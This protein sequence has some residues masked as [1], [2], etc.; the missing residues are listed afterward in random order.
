[1]EFSIPLVSSLTEIEA[2]ERSGVAVQAW[3]AAI[4]G[5][6]Y[7]AIRASAQRHGDAP[8][9]TY[10]DAADGPAR[11]VSYRE[12]LDNITA[13][14]RFFSELA[15]PGCG[16][17]YILPSFVETHYVLWG[18]E[19]CGFAVPLNPFLQ[20]DEI[21]NLVR[22]SAADVLVFPKGE[23]PGIAERVAAIR[24]NL[25]DVRL[26]AVGPGSAADFAI[27]FNAVLA[28]ST[29]HGCATWEPS[30]D[31]DA[32]VAYFHTGGTTGLPKLVAHSSRNQLAAALGAASLL[33]MRKDDRVTNGMPLFHVGGTIVSTLSVLLS[34]GHIIMLSAQ[35]LRNPAMVTGIWK[36]VER[37]GITI[38]GAVPTALGA[39]LNVPVD[40]DISSIRYGLTGA[41]PCPFSV[42]KRFA[43]VTGVELH[44][45]LGMTET[46]GATAA[47]AAG[48]RPTVGSVGYRLPFTRLRVRRQ[49]AEQGLGDDCD[50]HE[51]GVLFVEGPHVSH[52]YRDPSQNAGV[53]IE[54]G[55]NTGDLAYFD[56]AGKLFIA[57]RAKDLIIRSGH[58]IDP[59]MIE[60]AMM[61]HPSV[62][63]AAAVSLPDKYAGELPVV[64]VVAKPGVGINLE[65]LDAFVKE[66]IAERPAWPKAIH[67]LDQLPTTAVGKLFKP[68]LRV[69]AAELLLRPALETIASTALRAVEVSA[70]GKRGLH[71]DVRLVAPDAEIEQAVKVHLEGYTFTWALHRE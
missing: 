60:Q 28:D 17:A 44:E 71:V 41:A 57:G 10:I 34:G 56:D 62:A 24:A 70:G 14:A 38:F 49:D 7:G 51:V 68:A 47:D 9:L 36:I 16:V 58:N 35:G 29:A 1:M 30:G 64:F 67:V 2:I 6:V 23:I 19:A 52:G 40:A 21:V 42:T 53:F 50:P 31:S 27:D 37:F 32:V 33:G 55:L 43:E 12:L 4:G 69:K 63:L 45:L 66:R 26:V 48:Q 3:N 20:P 61:M 8:A 59:G 25:P 5:T 11:T 18:A 46:G 39:L 22:N 54:G 13:A 65:E 15:G